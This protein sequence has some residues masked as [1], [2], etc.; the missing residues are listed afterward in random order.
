MRFLGADEAE[1]YSKYLS[2][3]LWNTGKN[4]TYPRCFFTSPA[5]GAAS[6]RPQLYCPRDNGGSLIREA[7]EGEEAL[8]LCVAPKKLEAIDTLELFS[9]T[10]ALEPVLTEDQQTKADKTIKYIKDEIDRFRGGFP[11]DILIGAYGAA[12]W[13]AYVRLYVYLFDDAT[14]LETLFSSQFGGLIDPE[15]AL[16]RQMLAEMGSR[17]NPNVRWRDLFTMYF[18]GATPRSFIK[19]ELVK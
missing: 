15:N 14:P 3:Y 12:N 19:R 11:S 10:L 17:E 7:G 5:A 1:Y 8:V 2:C 13:K 16:H 6:D 4:G 9:E 18:G